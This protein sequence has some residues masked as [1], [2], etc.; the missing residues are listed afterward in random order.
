MAITAASAT[1]GY[2][3]RGNVDVTASLIVAAG[4][5]VGGVSGARFANLVS[6]KILSKMVG[7]IF[8]IL[9]IVM[10]ILRFI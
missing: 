8:V 1:L 3:Y 10:T 2:M 9:G 6:E 7:A 5:V 4:T